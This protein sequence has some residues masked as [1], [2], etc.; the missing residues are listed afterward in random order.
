MNKSITILSMKSSRS[1]AVGEQSIL[2]VLLLGG[3]LQI[4]CAFSAG[5][6][7]VKGGKSTASISPMQSSE[8]LAK[9]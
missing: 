7:L 5:S 4:L 9:K 1:Y 8:L 3:I 2:L 6:D